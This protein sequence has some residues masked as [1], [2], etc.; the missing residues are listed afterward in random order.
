MTKH[1]KQLAALRY[2]LQGREYYRALRVLEWA[3]PYHGGLRKDGQTPTFNHQV[4]ITLFI[5]RL[6]NLIHREDTIITGIIHDMFEDTAVT[7]EEAA[8]VAG[9]WTPVNAAWRMTKKTPDGAVRDE[10]ELYE[11]MAN[12][13]LASVGKGSDRAQ[14]QRTMGG[15]FTIEKVHSYL[16]YTDRLILPMLKIA[17]RRFPEQEASYELIKFMLTTQ[18]NLV[19]GILKD[20]EA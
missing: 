4:E 14:N 16:D 8:E 15:V 17:R 3:E 19:R 13:P 7:K 6:P 9:S 2:W 20:K 11:E 10:H 5:S 18:A 1:A 12:C